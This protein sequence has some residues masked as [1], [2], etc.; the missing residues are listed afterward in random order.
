[1]ELDVAKMLLVAGL[2]VSA[3]DCSKAF[4]GFESLGQ[5]LLIYCDKDHNGRG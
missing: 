5:S 3:C 1:L 4:P 2:V